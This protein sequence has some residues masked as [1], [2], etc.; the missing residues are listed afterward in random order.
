M[1]FSGYRGFFLGVMPFVLDADYLT[2]F[3]V[4]VNNEWGYTSSSPQC[5]Y[6]VDKNAFTFI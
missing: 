2:P 4:D 6:G 1:L 5:L 3:K